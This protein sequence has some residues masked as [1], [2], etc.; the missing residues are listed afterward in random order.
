MQFLSSILQNVTSYQELLTAIK[1]SKLPAGAIGLSLIN[2]A[3][4]ISSVY[5]DTGRKSIVIVSD[6]REAGKLCADLNAMGCASY[7]YAVKDLNFH[8]LDG[9]SHDYEHSRIGVLCR[10]LTGEYG[11]VVMVAAAAMQLTIPPEQLAE[12][13]LTLTAGDSISMT[14]CA[15]TLLSA[16][17]ERTHEVEGAG[18]F[19]VRG[20]ILDLY[21]PDSPSAVRV[22]FW[23]D[24]IDT[25]SY[26]DPLSQRR[27]DSL[28]SVRIL[29]AEEIIIS[30]KERL[31]QQL[32]DIAASLRGKNSEKARQKLEREIESLRHN[33]PV[34]PDKYTA[35]LCR[36]E[37][38]VLDYL[39]ENALVYSSDHFE[40]S[41]Q[42][43]DFENHSNEEVREAVLNG[44]LCRPLD[45][46]IIPA[47]ELLFKI[48]KRAVFLDTFA[49]GSYETGLKTLIACNANMSSAWSG[50]VSVLCED[51]NGLLRRGFSVAIMAG[52]ERA[53]LGLVKDLTSEE[54]KIP[55]FYANS[56][57]ELAPGKV[58]V[59]AG[60]FSAGFEYPDVLCSVITWGKQQPASTSTAKRKYKAGAAITD[61]AELS[62]GD[63]IVHE[64]YGIGV[65][66]GVQ[67]RSADG[68]TQAFIKIIYA[69][70]D[71]LYIP[72]T[73]LDL[74]S[75]Y[76]GGASDGKVKI[77]RLGSGDWQKQK[78]R[79]KKA[80]KD[81]AKE[82][83]KLYAERARAEGYPFSPDT[84][85]QRDF[86]N[87]FE[88][89][90]TD[91]QLRSI[92][93]IKQDMETAR[94]MDR[95]LCGDVGFGKTEVALRAAFKCVMEGRQCAILAPTTIL[96]WQHYQTA[97]R[98]FDQFPVKIEL[99][100]R[101][102][103]ASEQ[104]K[105]KK[106]L[107]SGDIDLVIGTHSLVQKGIEFSDIGLAIIDEEQ[108]F[109]VAQKE[110]FKEMLKSVDVLTLSATPI[111]RTLNLALSGMRDISV[112]EEAPHDRHPIQTYVLEYDDGIIAEAI[113]RELRRGGQVF[114]LHNRVESIEKTAA[115]IEKLVPEAV[116]AVAHGKM[117]E[118]EMSAV[119]QRLI[120]HDANVLVC[121]TIIETGVDVP[122]CNTL[123]IENAD[124]FGLSQ[125]H[126]IRGRVGRS[127]RRAYAY[128]TFKRGKSLAE[129]SAKRLEAIREFT[130]FGSGMKIAMR[131]LEL[132]GAGN[133]LGGEQSGNMET[134]GYDMYLKLLNQAVAEESGGADKAVNTECLI[135][136]TIDAYIPETYIEFL[137][138]RLG[139]YRK[140]A[141]IRSD[142]D[143]SD[144]LDELIDRFGEP[145][146][147][148]SALCDVALLKSR[149]AA[150]GITHIRQNGGK[151]ILSLAK[152]DMEQIF[153]FASKL[154]GRVLYTPGAKPYLTVKR[155]PK[156][157]IIDDVTDIVAEFSSAGGAV[158]R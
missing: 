52:S 76:I 152:A 34:A 20:G 104:T 85:W 22:E 139:I 133:I 87:K 111:P 80:V 148:V 27:S 68:I 96:A 40:L 145:P 94:P 108:R 72:I 82:L 71:I 124:C 98:R 28:S 83:T 6:D 11:S 103:T 143:R 13:T 116:V 110:R 125:L 48:E 84:E 106:R 16:G 121:T 50:S 99:L 120:E 69:Q 157:E 8:S 122:N 149:A 119:W 136:L 12:R 9:R 37:A 75:K 105:I 117:E 67:T 47:S 49:R 45:K 51:L 63:Y 97:L 114:Y 29:P 89:E 36:R 30:D 42:I 18:Q 129:M 15:E 138:T 39:D 25:I 146:A 21:P 61:L 154:R 112:L 118:N 73:Q 142:G 55:A 88:F 128:F 58:S 131:D 77:S 109:G 57:A 158:R 33:L 53:C 26:F 123:I 43:K 32:E 24:T 5:R 23:G 46:F 156:L 3:H 78:N 35:L 115:R 127:N 4:Y 147:T 92:A 19:S 155:N 38:T 31:A 1:Q 95:L 135:D 144:M 153:S 59:I 93:E 100:S 91:D 41:R 7:I 134:V 60:A 107:K 17:Y 101:F 126:Q 150:L 141:A 10:M 102:R 2:K 74:V 79:V 140:I 66:G 62:Q 132:R 90:E 81:I 151:Y 137:N 65:F 14:K 70:D 130:E 113:R 44:T 56:P 86:E 54:H 64:T